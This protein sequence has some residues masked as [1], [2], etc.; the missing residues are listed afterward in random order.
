MKCRNVKCENYNIEYFDNCK[1]STG[2]VIVCPDR[3]TPKSE[4][5]IKTECA[6]CMQDI[7]IEPCKCEKDPNNIAQHDIGAKLDDGKLLANI[8]Q[9]FPRALTA[10]LEVATFGAKKYSRGGWQHV[11]NGVERYS[12]AMIRHYLKEPLEDLDSDSGLTHEAHLAWNALARLELRL[13]K[14]DGND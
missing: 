9:Q 4:S 1:K 6:H 7:T 11:E 2:E 13:R 14:E 12:D 5:T 10:V 8:L 3:I